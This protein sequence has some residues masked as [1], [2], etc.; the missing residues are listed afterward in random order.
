MSTGL[1]V[2]IAAYACGTV[3]TV[4]GE[5]DLPAAPELR[6]AL[7]PLVRTRGL[8]ILDMAGVPFIDGACAGI[9]VGMHR[10]L[11][12]TGQRL[13]LANVHGIVSRVLD[14]AEVTNLVATHQREPGG[15]IAPWAAPA[16]S[17]RE[18]LE[19]LGIE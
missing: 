12:D 4:A 9:L 15:A 1:Q 7:L 2:H 13:V 18:V 3:V 14:L 16:A 19:A 6:E 10:R 11:A 8:L 5:L 17:A